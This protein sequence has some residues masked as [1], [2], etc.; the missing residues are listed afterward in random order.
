MTPLKQL[1][2]QYFNDNPVNAGLK[3]TYDTLKKDNNYS[4]IVHD[5][6]EGV[7]SEREKAFYTGFKTAV[8]LLLGANNEY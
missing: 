6:I 1:Y 7:E 3:V 4:T 8:Q 2:E 5:I